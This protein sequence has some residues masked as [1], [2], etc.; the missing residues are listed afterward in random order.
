MSEAEAIFSLIK[1]IEQSSKATRS[2]IYNLIEAIEDK[3]KL[4]Y[5]RNATAVVKRYIW[6]DSD[7]EPAG[8]ELLLKCADKYYVADVKIER[9]I[10]VKVNNVK[11][12]FS[13]ILGG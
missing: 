11:I 3:L 2:A 9:E 4:H 6:L 12:V 1:D 5:C 8:A 7:M 10:R 13:I